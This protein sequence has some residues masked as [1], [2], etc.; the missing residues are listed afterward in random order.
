MKTGRKSATDAGDIILN[1]KF[2]WGS[3]RTKGLGSY[4]T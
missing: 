1:S 3:V 4:Q 2:E